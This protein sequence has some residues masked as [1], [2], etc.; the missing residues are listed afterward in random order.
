MNFTI[1]HELIPVPASPKRE[2]YLR[3]AQ[4]AAERG[5]AQ[6][7]IIEVNRPV[8]AE[9]VVEESQAPSQPDQEDL[10]E[11]IRNSPIE[12]VVIEKDQPWQKGL[13]NALH[14]FARKG[15]FPRYVLCTDIQWFVKNMG[16]PLVQVNN[17]YYL[18]GFIRVLVERRLEREV[19]LLV[20]N[21]TPLDRA[22]EVALTIKLNKL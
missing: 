22:T 12:E 10:F 15:F 11:V 3:A 6:R 18:F 5:G 1:V 4:H 7:I 19:V 9:R 16:L 8:Y 17:V 14:Q 20:S 21:K 2:D 13:F